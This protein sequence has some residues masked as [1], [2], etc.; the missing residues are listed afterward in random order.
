M[1]RKRFLQ[2]GNITSFA[3]FRLAFHRCLRSKRIQLHLDSAKQ[4]ER[5]TSIFNMLE[6]LSL[7]L[8]AVMLTAH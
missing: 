6:F 3:R 4:K 8:H 5:K 2:P 1:D 7:R